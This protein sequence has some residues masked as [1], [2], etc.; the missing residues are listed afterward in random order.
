[1]LAP[2]ALL[3]AYLRGELTTGGGAGA[4]KTL[5]MLWLMLWLMLM[6]WL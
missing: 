1:M 2:A 5:L 6:W 3:A 4:E